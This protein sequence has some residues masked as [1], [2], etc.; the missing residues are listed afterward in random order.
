MSNTTFNLRG[1]RWL[2]VPFIAAAVFASFVGRADAQAAGNPIKKSGKYSVEL[3][4]PAEGLFAQQESDLE[5]RV[6]DAGQ[7]DPVLGAPPIV[8]AKVAATVTMPAMPSMPSQAPKTHSEGVAGDYGVVLYFPHGGEFLLSLRI[9]PPAD[10]PFTVSF[11]LPVNDP[12]GK[13]RNLR[14]APYY[15]EVVS[16]PK[17]PTSGKETDLTIAVHRRDDNSIV[18]EFD[19]AHEMKMHFI[20]VASDL[21]FFAHTHPDLDADG[22]FHLRYTFPA[23]GTYHLFADTAPRGAGSQ[24]L[25]QP[26][27]VAGAPPT[28]AAPLNP[29]EPA[30]DNAQGVKVSLLTDKSKLPSGRMIN[31]SFALTDPTGAKVMDTQPWLGAAGHLILIH[32]DG[33]TFVHSHPDESDAT[34]GKNGTITFLAR[35]PKAGIYRGWMQFQ[36]AGV[37]H[38]ATFV[39]HAGAGK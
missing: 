19:I 20:V 30:V 3:R 21:S 38:T 2:L 4:V 12:S 25:M 31:L 32:E 18:K 5:F 11:K 33:S 9:A 35:F 34:N 15:L 16:D 8:N 29:N 7:D 36:R 28:A 23:G 10:Q 26:L 6:T 39:L 24:V 22:K 17:L 13:A 27:T 37:V 1:R 14:P